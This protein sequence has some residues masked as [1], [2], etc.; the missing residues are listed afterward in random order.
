MKSSNPYDPPVHQECISPA[1]N[2]RPKFVTIICILLLI[3]AV[4]ALIQY[5]SDSNQIIGTWYA[6]YN[7]SFVILQALCAVGMWKMKRAAFFTFISLSIMNLL[8]HIVAVGFNLGGTLLIGVVMYFLF[9]CIP[10]V[11]DQNTE[12]ATSPNH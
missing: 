3:G 4:A 8:V 10:R 6:P 9:K 5:N 1:S 2:P 12:Q 7:A 11:G